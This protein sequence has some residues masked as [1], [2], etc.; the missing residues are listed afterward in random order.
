MLAVKSARCCQHDPETIYEFALRSLHLPT[1]LF[2]RE[3][4]R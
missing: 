4:D 3:L 2:P 1:A